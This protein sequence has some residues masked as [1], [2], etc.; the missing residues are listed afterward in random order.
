MEDNG[1]IITKIIRVIGDTI[2][3][4]LKAKDLKMNLRMRSEEIEEANILL[5]MR[6]RKISKTLTMKKRMR[7]TISTDIATTEDQE[8]AEEIDTTELESE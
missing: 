6:T 2:T 5:K 4:I 3:M 1:I 7:K 8:M